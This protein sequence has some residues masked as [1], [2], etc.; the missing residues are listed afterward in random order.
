VDWNSLANIFGVVVG[1][2]E[3]RFLCANC[4]EEYN[5]FL[6]HRLESVPRNLSQ[7]QELATS[8]ALREDA[9]KHMLEWLAKRGL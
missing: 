1:A 4:T 5:R 3:A 7:D 2:G 8:R 9:H 6:A